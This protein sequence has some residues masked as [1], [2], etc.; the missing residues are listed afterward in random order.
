MNCFDNFL[1][2]FSD[3]LYY[4]CCQ[5]RINCQKIQ[6]NSGKS[7]KINNDLMTKRYHVISELVI[8][9]KNVD[10]TLKLICYCLSAR[11]TPSIQ[12]NMYFQIQISERYSTSEDQH[13][14]LADR[15][16]FGP[17]TA[18]HQT[19]QHIS[20]NEIPSNSRILNST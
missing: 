4:F 19:R 18:Q 17:M 3:C 14:R 1:L 11:F 9:M 15:K 20:D 5:I 10:N 6:E 8:H 7:M 16:D 12:N 13:P 2:V